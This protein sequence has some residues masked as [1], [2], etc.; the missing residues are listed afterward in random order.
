MD[1]NRDIFREFLQTKKPTAIDLLEPD[2]PLLKA[3][4][5]MPISRCVRWHSIIGARFTALDGE[6]AD[7][8]IRESSARLPGAASELLVSARHARVN[9]VDA[10]VD[11]LARI[12]REHALASP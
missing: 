10:S 5:R 6:A 8:I 9:K 12:L 11:E 7:G 3:M 1:D 4:A 2:N